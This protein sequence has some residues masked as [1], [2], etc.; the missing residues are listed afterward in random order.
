LRFA[1]LFSVRSSSFVCAVVQK[2]GVS[3]VFFLS[4]YPKAPRESHSLDANW[5]QHS[6]LQS[7]CLTNHLQSEPMTRNLRALVWL[8]VCLYLP[9]LPVWSSEDVEPTASSEGPEIEEY[10][11]EEGHNEE[12]GEEG[13]PEG[14]EDESPEEEQLYF[15]SDLPDVPIKE[16]VLPAEEDVWAY[17]EFLLEPDPEVHRIV[18]FYAH[19]CPHCHHI[20]GQ[21]IEFAKRIKDVAQHYNVQVEVYAVSCVP[22]RPVCRHFE[23]HGYPK[24]LLFRAGETEPT[25]IEHQELHPYAV[26][27]KIGLELDMD[28]EEDTEDVIGAPIDESSS[29]TGVD[30]DYFLPRRKK[31]IYNDAYLSFHFAM[32]NGIFTDQGPLSNSTRE[33]FTDFLDLV[34]ATMPPSFNLN[35]LASEI[36]L[37][38]DEALASE[39]ALVALVDKY[40]PKKK[41]WSQSCTRGDPAMGYTCGLWELFH[42]ISVGV[43]E[44]NNMITAEGTS[45]ESF[46]SATNGNN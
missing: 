28:L 33:Y 27:R 43:V 31:D 1:F 26:L 45:F 2:Q 7:I 39:E 6:N 19:W 32:K 21:Y 37:N 11:G 42:I 14:G 44:Y 23:V 20:K 40:P 25:I 29:G 5:N 3:V 24:I 10:H 17:H 13:S 35:T 30:Q 8:I 15:Y 9:A 38:S 22:F 36:L 41:S 4:L 12:E 16:F 46:D 34:Q 18:E